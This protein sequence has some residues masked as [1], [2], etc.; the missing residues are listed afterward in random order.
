MEVAHPVIPVEDL[1]ESLLEDA[2]VVHL[3]R[4]MECNIGQAL[5]I[6]LSE[7]QAW[8]FRDSDISGELIEEQNYGNIIENHYW[9]GRYQTKDIDGVRFATYNSDN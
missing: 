3:S 2:E 4:E 7:V 5:G 9:S 1:R 8:Y 6:N